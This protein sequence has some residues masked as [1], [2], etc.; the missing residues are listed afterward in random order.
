MIGAKLAGGIGR[1]VVASLLLA[2]VQAWGQDALLGK[3]V[4]IDV[5]AQPLSSALVDF[6]RAAGVQIV[7]QTAVVKNFS[8]HGVHGAKTIGDALTE[9]LDG[10]G[11]QFRQAGDRTIAVE[12]ATPPQASRT[13]S[14]TQAGADGKRELDTIYVTAV[15][16]ALAATRSATPIR[17]IPQSVSIISQDTINQQNA[18]DIASALQQAT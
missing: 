2:S 10:T 8:T 9:L 1:A 18:T 6:S 11:L 15:A 4:R 5:K 3:T 12:E 16:E 7:A 17:E 14:D 13:S